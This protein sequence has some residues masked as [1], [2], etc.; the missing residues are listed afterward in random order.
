MKRCYG[1]TCRQNGNI[2]LK[3]LSSAAQVIMGLAHEK[4]LSSPAAA[5]SQKKY[6]SAFVP[7]I[8]ND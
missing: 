7:H 6:I 3:S 2:Y 4:T 8:V 5:G 1:Y